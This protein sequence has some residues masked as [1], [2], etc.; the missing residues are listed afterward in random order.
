MTKLPC[1]VRRVNSKV[2][3]KAPEQQLSLSSAE[4]SWEGTS[5]GM[6]VLSIPGHRQDSTRAVWPI[7][8]ACSSWVFTPFLENPFIPS[9][10]LLCPLY[11]WRPRNGLGL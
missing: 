7:K 11:L 3:T 1:P 5:G 4:G 2:V 9:L 10:R 6:E 8:A